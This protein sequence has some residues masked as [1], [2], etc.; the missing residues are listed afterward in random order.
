[1]KTNFPNDSGQRSA[2]YSSDLLLRQYRRVKGKRKKPS[3]IR[4]LNPSILSYCLKRVR[5]NFT[6]IPRT[7]F[8]D[9]NSSLILGWNWNYCKN[10]YLYHLTFSVQTTTMVLRVTVIVAEPVTAMVKIVMVKP[11]IRILIMTATVKAK[12][13]SRT[14]KQGCKSL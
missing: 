2:C 9:L 1:M 11:D 13:A 6:N 8:T 14:V 7:I 5:K 4:I 3:V 10:I 12:L